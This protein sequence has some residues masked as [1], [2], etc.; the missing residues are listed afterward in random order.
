[1][2]MVTSAKMRKWMKRGG[3]GGFAKPIRTDVRRGEIA[4]GT[5]K[6]FIGEW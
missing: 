5:M 1:M 6:I 2:A 4:T 3:G